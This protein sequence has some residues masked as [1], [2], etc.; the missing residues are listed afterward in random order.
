M[1]CEVL[2]VVAAGAWFVPCMTVGRDSDAEAYLCRACLPWGSLVLWLALILSG[3]T[4]VAFWTCGRDN[5]F[6]GRSRSYYVR[7]HQYSD[8]ACYH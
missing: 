4:F 7:T 2:G 6:Q 8:R 5:P 3:F 1:C